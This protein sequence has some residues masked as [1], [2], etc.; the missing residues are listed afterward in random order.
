MQVWYILYSLFQ[1]G[2]GVQKP[3]RA[4]ALCD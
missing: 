4:L 1:H 3:G 2:V